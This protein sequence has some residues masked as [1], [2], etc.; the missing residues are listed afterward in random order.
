MPKYHIS[1]D[2]G[3]PNI[4]RAIDKC[5]IGGEHYDSK[6]EAR[7]GYEAQQSGNTFNSVSKKSKKSIDT[8]IEETNELFDEDPSLED[9]KD[10][11]LNDSEINDA[12]AWAD[13]IL[14]EV[15]KREGY[16]EVDSDDDYWSDDY[17][18]DNGPPKAYS[19]D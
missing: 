19:W 6:D 13:S 11:E 18:E 7:S 2:T 15:R 12:E 14:G 16:F 3:R 5:P 17:E 8:E 1:P 4:C 9:L 10:L